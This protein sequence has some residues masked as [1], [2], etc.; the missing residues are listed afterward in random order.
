MRRSVDMLAL[1]TILGFLGIYTAVHV[2]WHPPVWIAASYAAMSLITLIVYAWD[3]AAA[4]AGRWRTS[5]ATLHLLALAGGWPG[6]LLAQ[7]WLRHKSAKRAFRA[8]FWVTV[9]LNLTGL[10]VVCS[11]WGL[12]SQAV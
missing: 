11:P 12:Y 1:L 2:L 3:K 6:A 10:V 5:E 8:V 4:Q 9:V 7:H